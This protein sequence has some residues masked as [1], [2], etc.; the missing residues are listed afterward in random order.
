MA[1]QLDT[2]EDEYGIKSEYGHYIG[3]EWIQGDSGKTID[4][5]N[6]ANGKVLT[7]IQAGNA[8]DIERA[9]SAAKDAFPKWSQSSANE[10]QDILIEIARRLKERHSHYATLETLNNGKPMRES[11]YFDMPQAIGQFELFAGAAFGLHGKTHDY[12]DAIG[13]VHREPLGVCA[14]IIPWNVPML[15]MACKIAPAL[16]S[17][18]TVVLK[19]AE[20]VCLS[21]IEF[22]MEMADLLPPGVINVVTGYGQDVG[23][24]LVTHPDVVKVAFTGSVATARR[25][26]QYASAN[27]IPQTMELGGKSAHIICEDADIDAAVESATMSTVL[28][29]GEVCLAGSR[30]FLHQ[31]IEEEFLEKFKTALEGIR[32]GDPLDMA[33]QL[34]AQASKMQMDKVE[35][36]L[37]LATEEGAHVLTGGT[38]SDN[39]D[40]ASGHFIKPTVFTNVKN[41]MRIA[42]E[43]IFGPVTSV[44]TW[45][46]E[47]EM[48]KQANDTSYGLAGGV[49][50]ANLNRAHRISRGLETGTVWV[51]RY[52]N[53]QAN[54]PVGGYKQS[55]FGREFSHEVLNH[56]TQTKSV[57]INLQEGRVGMF[58]Q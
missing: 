20:T 33:T 32:Q 16:A 15:M 6:P 41:S 26:I 47:D 11:M 7:K 22:F 21:V 50:T 12:A 28:N 42:R 14:Q 23:E 25:I 57:V 17:G 2:T 46:D 37:S 54:M 19:P 38:R 52:Y 8:K 24:A 51:N 36:Y 10:R 30:L 31:S 56:Y 34:G 58:D 3:G 35:S 1:T 44:I 40:L 39:A 5:I 18:N 55:G 45:S 48:M 43:E 49:W 53:M 9:V 13:I 27:I 29:K 4:L